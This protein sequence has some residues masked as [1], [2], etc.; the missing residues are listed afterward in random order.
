MRVAIDYRQRVEQCIARSEAVADPID[1]ARWLQL[2][3]QWALLSR[4]RFQS[5]DGAHNEPAGLW[6]GDVISRRPDAV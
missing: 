6:R 5:L 2:A 4:L 1:R 3:E